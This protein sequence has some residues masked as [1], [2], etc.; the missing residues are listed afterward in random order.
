MDTALG[1]RAPQH[2]AM[3]CSWAVL[4]CQS[5]GGQPG[6]RGGQSGQGVSLEGALA[7]RRVV[8]SSPCPLLAFRKAFHGTENDALC[9]EHP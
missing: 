4:F 7:E 8:S 3:R 1:G 6:D 5:L 2:E 9:P